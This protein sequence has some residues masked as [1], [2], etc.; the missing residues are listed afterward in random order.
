M[1]L[2]RAKE[3]WFALPCSSVERILP[4]VPLIPIEEAPPYVTGAVNL[5]AGELLVVDFTYLVTKSYL[6]PKMHSRLVIIRSPEQGGEFC[7]LAEQVTRT[8]HLKK[9]EFT[10]SKIRRDEL[11][12][13]DGI[14]TAADQLIQLIDVEELRQFLSEHIQS[15]AKND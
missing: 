9:V 2:L 4:S 11:P 14:Y 3:K 8:V 1:L 7:L 12:F 5:P 10:E 13:L 6:E 15:R